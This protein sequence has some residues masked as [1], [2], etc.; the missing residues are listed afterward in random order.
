MNNKLGAFGLA[1]L[2]TSL[3]SSGG[4]A[5]DESLVLV[6]GNAWA[7]ISADFT[8]CELSD[9][10]ILAKGLLDINSDFLNPLSGQVEASPADYR[11][12]FIVHSPILAEDSPASQSGASTLPDYG[13]A[14]ENNYIIEEVEVSYDFAYMSGEP[15]PETMQGI[16]ISFSQAASATITAE[17]KMG[18]AGQLR[19]AAGLAV[20]LIPS[21][22]S[23][24]LRNDPIV[25]ANGLLSSDSS[26]LVLGTRIVVRGQT[27]G[28]AAF[29]TGEFNYPVEICLNCVATDLIQINACYPPWQD[30]IYLF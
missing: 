2:T 25:G 16:P 6:I 27:S 5:S 20:D 8:S 23:A 14:K 30:Q 21:S 17:S 11:A 24:L 4:C 28:G 18:Q 13:P 19:A 10:D 3:V 12:N 26:T 1:M 15:D 22:I 7:P 29:E 9:K